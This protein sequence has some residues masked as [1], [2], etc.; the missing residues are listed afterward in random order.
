MTFARQTL[1]STAAVVALGALAFAWSRCVGSAAARP[2]PTVAPTP[3]PRVVRTAD[4]RAF[5]LAAP[6]AR[7]FLASASV[8]DF[9]IDLIGPERVVGLCEHAFTA[10]ALAFAPAPYA[11][12]PRHERFLAEPTLAATPD[13]VLCSDYNDPSTLA[14]LA[15]AGVPVVAVPAVNSL[16]EA[17]RALDLIGHLLGA[18]A[19]LASLRAEL[20]RRCAALRARSA[21]RGRRALCFTHNPTGTW[22]GGRNTL[23]D[24]ALGLAGLVNVAT[25]AGI[26]GHA[27]IA[28]ETILALDP[29]VIVLDAPVR[30]A[31]G[32]RTQL[33]E[34]P[35][36]SHLRA[37]VSGAVVELHPALYATGSHRVVEAAEVIAARVEALASS[38]AGK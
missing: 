8:V 22:T 9:A 7:V 37:L 3:F 32:S 34:H 30:G 15:V 5:E 6:P 21:G 13:L 23:H 36:L 28:V 35:A 26:V 14:A 1:I 2:W 20:D 4:E 38:G 10:S 11:R 12:V 16:E 17:Q 29:D 31:R 19:P 27:P 25:D 18:D 24:E 33:T